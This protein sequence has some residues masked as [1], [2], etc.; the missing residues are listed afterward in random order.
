[1]PGPRSATP[2]TAE[3]PSRPSSTRTST[4]A[5]AACSLRVVEEVAD[6]PLDPARV[7]LDDDEV[8]RH[9]ADGLGQAGGRDGRHELDE[10]DRL[11]R[12]LLRAGVEARDL[13]QVVDEDPQP[14]D[15]GD[16]ELAGPAAGVGHRP[17]VL[18]Q[19]RRLG[20]ERRERRPQLVRDVGDE[21]PVVGLGRLEPADRLLERRRHP[22]ERLGPVAE[23]VGGRDRHARREVAALDPLGRP[24]C[25]LDGREDAARNGPRRDERDDDQDQRAGDQPDAERRQRRLD[26]G[27]VVDEVERRAGAGQPAADD[28][29]RLARRSSATGSRSR[30][31]RRPPR[32]PATGATRTPGAAS[33]KSATRSTPRLRNVS[34]RPLPLSASARHLRQRPGDQHPGRTGPG[35]RLRP[36][37]GRGASSRRRGTTRS[38]GAP[39][40][41]DD[42][43]DDRERQPAADAP[44]SSGHGAQRAGL[45]AGAADGLDQL[46]CGRI[47]LD[48]RPEPLDRDVDEPRIAEVVVAPDPV[49]Q[50]VAAQDLAGVAGELDEEVEL[51][52]GERRCRGRRASPSGRRGR[53]RRA[54]AE[55]VGVAGLAARPADRGP[56]AGDELRD[57]ERLLDVV[58]GAG[59][60][61]DDDV[62]RVGAR[63]EHDDRDGRG[64]ADG[65]ADLEA[66]EARQHHVEQDQ[67]ERL[68]AEPVEAPPGRRPRRRRRSPRCAGRSRDLADRRVVLDEQ[69]P[70]VHARQYASRPG[71]SGRQLD[72]CRRSPG[73]A[74]AP[75]R[76]PGLAVARPPI[77]AAGVRPAVGGRLPCGLAAA[78][79]SSLRRAG[80]VPVRSR[81]RKSTGP[82]P[83][84]DRARDLGAGA[85]PVRRCDGPRRARSDAARARARGRRA[86][87]ARAVAGRRSDAGGRRVARRPAAAVGRAGPGGRPAAVERPSARPW[88]PCE[89]WRIG[90]GR[91]DRSGS[92]PAMTSVGIRW[93][94]SASISRRSGALVDADERDRVAVAP[95]PAGPADPVDVVLGDHRQLEVHDVRQVLDVEAARRDLGGDED[96]RP[97][98]LEVVERPDPLALALVAVDRGRG[99]AVACELLGE[100]VRAVLGPG[101]DERLLDAAAPDRGG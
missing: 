95:G 26:R 31:G 14:G 90:S 73:M 12:E 86:A 54:E 39:A 10:V 21:A 88:P 47:G 74:V 71:V 25:F 27:R 55:R 23:L 69:D 94:S 5:P 40:V 42:E 100:A 72:R 101:E 59:L 62:D 3:A 63:G 80:P 78:R 29:A 48:L 77:R 41:S 30:L 2:T 18:A 49:E 79:R 99:D 53:S 22:V 60:E 89:R 50:D 15:V 82:L 32:S 24:G 36:G 37:P 35:S 84:A 65:A 6:D 87:G 28:E 92:K 45:V 98:G 67:V 66:V 51:G 58:V 19:D 4:G 81:D 75:V 43:R 70:G 7:G 33:P 93:R 83:I 34:W 85:A 16:E 68:G 46:R 91:I 20:D 13:H 44:R 64:P 38:R 61:P 52:P 17:E 56:D 97:A 9:R 8:R 57:L 1:M 11:R 96:R 76:R